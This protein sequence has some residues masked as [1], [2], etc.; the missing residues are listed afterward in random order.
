MTANDIQRALCG[1]PGQTIWSPRD[2]LAGRNIKG[3]TGWDADLLLITKSNC[4]IEVE[5]KISVSDFRAEFKKPTKIAKHKMF[6]QGH[7]LSKRY[8]GTCVKTP[9]LIRNY[10]FA[11]PYS[12]Y[13]KVQDEIPEYA[14]VI[15]ISETTFRHG[16][17]LYTPMIVKKAPV[18]KAEKCGPEHRLK[19]LTA[20]YYR[21]WDRHSGS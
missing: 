8:R 5:I 2:V 16:E 19:I 13:S 7:T 3:V 17:P 18:L 12:V 20:K 15:V 9:N 4:A 11:M 21:W 1:G 6:T 14:G 10:Y